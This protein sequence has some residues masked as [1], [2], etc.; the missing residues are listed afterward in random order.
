M[1]NPRT[2]PDGTSQVDITA[3]CAT[4]ADAELVHELTQ[5]AFATL[6]G[7]IDPPSSAH[8]ETMADVAQALAAGGGGI[9]A[10]DGATVGAVRFLPKVDHLYVGR[11]A[12][13]P[14]RR[15][16]GVARALMAFAEGEAARLGLPET[17]IQVRRSLTGD[18]ALFE[19]LGYR[20]VDEQP[21]PKNPAASVLTLAKPVPP[22]G[23]GGAG[24][25]VSPGGT[26]RD[27]VDEEAADG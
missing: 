7:W 8:R 18:V 25:P 12:V 20:V 19:R 13:D 9:A 27:A 26:R 1:S 21:H 5:V 14:A 17:R 24:E 22:G 23:S 10:V 4:T 16:R 11:V 15:G 6:A 3:R 2:Q